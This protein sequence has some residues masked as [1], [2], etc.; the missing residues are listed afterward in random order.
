MLR[1]LEEAG[2]RRVEGMKAGGLKAA[3]VAME[4][5]KRVKLNFMVS[6]LSLTEIVSYRVESLNLFSAAVCSL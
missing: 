6:N 3:A 2:P 1:L 4:E 5:T